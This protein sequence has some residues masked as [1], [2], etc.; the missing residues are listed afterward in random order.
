[1]NAQS[2]VVQMSPP[3]QIP[4][5]L[6]STEAFTGLDYKESEEFFNITVIALEGKYK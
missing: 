1:M 2:A 5:P 3:F 6:F 4:G